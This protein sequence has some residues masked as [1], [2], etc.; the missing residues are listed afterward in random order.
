MLQ[1]TQ[2]TQVNRWKQILILPMLVAFVFLFNTEVVAKEVA[3]VNTTTTSTE[4]FTV[5]EDAGDLVVVITK[6]TTVD[7]LKAYKK[8]FKSQKITFEYSDVD[9]NSKGEIS[10]ISL[11]LKTK[12]NAAN[13]KFE[14]INDKAISD[15]HVGKRGDELFVKSKGIEKAVKG[16]YAY[17]VTS[18]FKEDGEEEEEGVKSQKIVFRTGKDGKVKVNKWV[19]KKDVQT[20]DIKKDGDKEV[21]I[22]NGK[23]LRPDEIIE[24]E[25]E[26]KNG[27]T[28]TTSFIY[29]VSSDE[30]GEKEEGEEEEQEVKVIK[31]ATSKIKFTSTSTN[32][33]KKPLFVV[34]G[35][36]VPNDYFTKLDP[37]NIE[38]ITVLKDKSAIKQYG[39][40]GK[41]GVIIVKT[42]KKTLS[43]I[44]CK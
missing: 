32:G 4:F 16:A 11:V 29:T 19:E 34:D 15:I 40:K 35:K 44:L 22:I 42:K 14:T 3:T 10:G 21:I 18:E 27:D 5:E 12:D 26:I 1:K 13:G 43:K 23:E 17:T 38:S 41:N 39:D 9:F 20:I 36:V 8:L 33:E 31:H 24:E 6:N 25:I 2:S 7:E 28:T 30:D 37:D